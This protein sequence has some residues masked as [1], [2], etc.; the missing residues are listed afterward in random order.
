[1]EGPQGTLGS[2]GS[3]R[4]LWGVFGNLGLHTSLEPPFLKNPINLPPVEVYQG[5][6][7]VPFQGC[8]I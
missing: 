3:L 2:L 8:R 4:K 7:V 1:M 6:E 5:R